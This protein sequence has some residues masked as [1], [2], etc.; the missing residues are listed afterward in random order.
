MIGRT[1]L[2]VGLIAL[3]ALTACGPDEPASSGGP[4]AM[5]RLTED[6]YR[7]SVV[8]IFGPDIK[9]AGRFEPDNRK[10]G[11]LAVGTALVTVSPTGFE[12]YDS[13]ARTIAAQVVDEHHRDASMPCRP[14]SATEPDPACAAQFFT[15]YGR[16]LFRRPL[17]DEELTARVDVANAAARGTGD[18]YAGL[19]LGLA[20]LM[21][22]PAFLFRKDVTIADPSNPGERRLD[23]YSKAARISFFLWNTTPD[24]ELLKAAEHGDL[25]SKRGLTAQVDRMLASPRLEQGVR[26]FFSDFLGFDAMDTLSK[27][28]LIYPK[29]NQK[30][31]A[32]AREQTLRTVAD[33]VLTRRADYRDLFTTRRTF[34]DRTLGVVYNVPVDTHKGWQPFEFPEGDPRAGLL[35]QISFT[36]LHSHPG[37][38]SATLRGKAIRE[39]LLCQKVPDPP[40]NVNFSIVQDT[41]NPQFKT[42]RERLEAHRTNPTCAGC[43]KLI[44]PIG[45]SLENFDGLGQYRAAENG[46]AIDSGGEFDGFRFKDAVGLGKALHD[47]PATVSCLVDSAYRYG[48]GRKD[49]P[50]EKA[51]N[52]YL[53]KAFA[54]EGYRFTDLLRLIAT[55]DAFYKVSAPAAVCRI[56]RPICEH[57][58]ASADGFTRPDE[59]RGGIGGAAVPRLLPERQR[60]G[61]GGRARRCRCVSA[62]GSGAAA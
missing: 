42:A 20:S 12:Q 1:R 28:S 41:N 13:M 9:I 30:V 51:W 47:D 31:V 4:A 32:D 8:D 61:A 15:K 56:R 22:A 21:N 14:K 26:A 29:Y 5:R 53:E 59:R 19:Q 50:G 46:V 48:V 11:L 2:A 24:D 60:H 6:Q 25:D 18:F 33:H 44:D 10:D 36:A 58:A 34:M 54:T 52:A 49:M 38:S 7:Q 16:L 43:H 62:P 27:D 55:S 45:L 17:T 37:R 23:A 40:A 57:F 39:I 3:L 35:T